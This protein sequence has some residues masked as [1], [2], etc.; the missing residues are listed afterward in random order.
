M[1]VLLVA[2]EQLRRHVL[3]AITPEDTLLETILT[4]LVV[5]QCMGTQ[6]ETRSAHP[7]MLAHLITPQTLSLSV[8][9]SVLPRTA[10]LLR[11][12]TTPIIMAHSQT[13]TRHP[14]QHI[15]PQ[16]LTL[17]PTTPTHIFIGQTTMP[18]RMHLMYL[19]KHFW[20]PQCQRSKKLFQPSS[21]CK[22][23]QKP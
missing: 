21:K 20:P 16:A 4:L 19:H 18:L 11:V 14:T 23:R 10:T 13:I 5:R 15:R 7:T 8:Q 6:Q 1:P 17:A 12:H 2:Q 3:R 22:S 9:H